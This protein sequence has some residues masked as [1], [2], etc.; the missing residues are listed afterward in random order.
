MLR[1]TDARYR[2][3]NMVSGLTE[4]VVNRPLTIFNSLLLILTGYLSYST[5]KFQRRTSVREA[6]EQ[7]EDVHFYRGK[8]T[9]IL[10][11]FEFN[12]VFGTSSS[13]VKLKYY[14]YGRNPATA[15]QET[16]LFSATLGRITGSQDDEM[17]DTELYSLISE[18]LENQ[19]GVEMAQ[20]SESGIHVR[21]QTANAVQIRRRTEFLLR[22]LSDAHSVNADNLREALSGEDTDSP[23]SA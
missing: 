8:I 23:E 3:V 11:E 16:K 21:F 14:K 13:D 9:P 6:L 18:A 7:L 19:P 12:P 5:F 4:F 10:N 17:D 15:N 22:F 20:A 1:N 2:S